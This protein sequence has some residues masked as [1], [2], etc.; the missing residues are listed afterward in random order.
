MKNSLMYYVKLIRTVPR[1][2]QVFTK[3]QLVFRRD[4]KMLKMNPAVAMNTI[5]PRSACTW[6]AEDVVS[7]HHATALRPG[8]REGN[9]VQKKKK[10]HTYPIPKRMLFKKKKKKGKCVIRNTNEPRRCY[11]E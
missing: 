8:R 4:E 3:V 11:T 1:R 9:S 5:V 10:R 6:E 7:Q 2:N